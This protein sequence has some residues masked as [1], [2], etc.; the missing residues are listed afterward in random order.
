MNT[1]RIRQQHGRLQAGLGRVAELRDELHMLTVDTV[2]QRLDKVRQFFRTV[3]QPYARAEE[4]ILYPDM[5]V[6]FNVHLSSGLLREHGAIERRLG[7]LDDV[8]RAM[9]ASGVVP[10][11]LREQLDGLLRVMRAHLR[12]QEEV[13][14]PVLDASLSRKQAEALQ[15]RMETVWSHVVVARPSTSSPSPRGPIRA[16]ADGRWRAVM[17]FARYARAPP[18]MAAGRPPEHVRCS[19]EGNHQ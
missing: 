6:R 4:V 14:L 13:I 18:A 9:D 15:D 3:V 10:T 12:D 17:D 5:V 19:P 11:G 8:R 7:A 2:K 16:A 1:N